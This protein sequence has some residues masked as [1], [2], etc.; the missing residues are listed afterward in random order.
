MLTGD[1]LKGFFAAALPAATWGIQP[2]ILAAF[3]AFLGHLY[4]VFGKFRG[5]S[6]IAPYFGALVLFHTETALIMGTNINL[7]NPQ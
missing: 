1:V 7:I 3:G 4:P 6:G 5:G 2:A